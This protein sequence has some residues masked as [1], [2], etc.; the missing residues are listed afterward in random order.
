MLDYPN[1]FNNLTPNQI[2]CIP[3]RTY[4]SCI[5]NV[6]R[7]CFGN[8]NY[9]GVK[10]GVHNKMAQQNCSTPGIIY[11]PRL[12]GS[13]VHPLPKPGSPCGYDGPP[14][15]KH[16]GLFGDPHLKTFSNEFQTCK[17][18]G[19]WPLI[20]NK[21]LTVQV[22]NDPV[23]K[24]GTATATSKVRE[25]SGFGEESYP[26]VYDLC[27]TPIHNIHTDPGEVRHLA[28]KSTFLQPRW[29]CL[30]DLFALHWLCR[31]V[32]EAARQS[33]C[34]AAVDVGLSHRKA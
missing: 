4:M 33:R 20:N 26:A 24:A 6:S 30:I 25:G 28:W 17:V 15:Y 1:S 27:S 14:V 10:E 16:C 12:H 11:D 8:I 21:H 32:L 34:L 5:R 23:G 13:P 7:G 9:H 31:E 18:R 29:S 19:A 3:L 2:K 22:T